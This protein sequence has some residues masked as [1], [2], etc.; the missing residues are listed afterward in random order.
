MNAKHEVFMQRLQSSVRPPTEAQISDA[1][2]LST[3]LAVDIHKAT[4]AAVTLEIVTKF[5]SD[6][7]AVIT[8]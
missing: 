5:V 3:A 4:T 6:W 7:T 8:A 2:Q 1:V